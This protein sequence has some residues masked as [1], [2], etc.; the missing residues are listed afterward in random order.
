[1][2]VADY[3]DLL[4]L[5]L[6]QERRSLLVLG[7]HPAL[8]SRLGR[9]ENIRLLADGRSR[10][11]LEVSPRSADL[12]IQSALLTTLREDESVQMRLLALESL[13]GSQVDPGEIWNAIESAGQASDPAIMQ[14]AILLSDQL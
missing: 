2:P 6:P 1:M 7:W 8:A 4:P 11:S 12:T 10:K 3:F 5:L 13:V 14:H 9:W